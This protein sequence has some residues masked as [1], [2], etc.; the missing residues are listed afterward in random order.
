MELH[1][2]RLN[3]NK[4]LIELPDYFEILISIASF[5]FADTVLKPVQIQGKT[6]IQ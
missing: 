3:S 2:L 5:Y 6:A 1:H 4:T